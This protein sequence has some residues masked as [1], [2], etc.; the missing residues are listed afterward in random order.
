[1][2]L[3]KHHTKNNNWLRSLLLPLRTTWKKKKNMVLQSKFRWKGLWLEAVFSREQIKCPADLISVETERYTADLGS[4]SLLETQ[5]FLQTHFF[6]SGLPSRGHKALITATKTSGFKQDM[7]PHARF[8][9]HP[10]EQKLQPR[11]NFYNLWLNFLIKE[12]WDRRRLIISLSC[13]TWDG[14]HLGNSAL[15]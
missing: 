10:Q 15:F 14:L 7:R 8:S 6:H 9:H 5:L 4:S 2:G 1:M 3:L 13:L 12:T 11:E